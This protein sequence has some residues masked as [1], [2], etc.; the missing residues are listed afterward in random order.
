MTHAFPKT[1]EWD[2]GCKL[3][4]GVATRTEC[5]SAV[6]R[7]G[8]A[9]ANGNINCKQRLQSWDVGHGLQVQSGSM[10]GSSF[11]TAAGTS[12]Y[13]C[14]RWG[15]KLHALAAGTGR[16]R[17]QVGAAAWYTMKGLLVDVAGTSE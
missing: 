9:G 13:G 11:S 1:A 2:A 8:N 17:L 16:A 7:S 3:L 5:G 14:K 10:A 12:G 6:A 15:Q 4:L